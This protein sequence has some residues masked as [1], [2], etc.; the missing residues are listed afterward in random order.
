M[1]NIKSIDDLRKACYNYLV[2]TGKRIGIIEIE[3][4][5]LF[6]L[7]GLDANEC[8]SKRKT[9]PEFHIIVNKDT[10]I[11][12]FHGILVKGVQSDKECINLI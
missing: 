2:E 7:I 10:N 4:G 1:K 5:L 12:L 3:N 9:K 6:R 8:Y 11:I